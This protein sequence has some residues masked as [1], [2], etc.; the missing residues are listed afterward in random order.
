ML[1]HLM[2]G[3]SLLAL[4]LHDAENEAGSA[5]TPAELK[6]EEIAKNT[7]IGDPVEKEEKEEDKGEID[8]DAEI[9]PEEVELDADGNPIEKVEETAEEKETR[10]KTEREAAKANRKEQRIQKRIDTAVA[11]QKT[12]EAEVI[13]L[14]AQLAAKTEGGETLTEADVQARADAIA[15]EKFTAKEVERAQD[16]FTAR[17]DKL[18]DA[19][20]KLDKDFT[21]NVNLMA[22]ELG[23]IPST[24]VNSI[25]ELENGAE[26]LK[27]MVDDVDEAEKIYDLKNKPVR[28]GMA[29]ARISDR[30][31]EEKKPKPKVISK[32]PNPKEPVNGSRA[33]STVITGK[34]STEEYI[35]K[36][37]AQMKEKREAGR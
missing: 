26:V 13:K 22:E 1:K 2:S 20:V 23:P 34:E 35:R 17:C 5:K 37:Q 32:V 18:H 24:V 6:R 31:I 9:D 33:T 16:E 11:A 30:L 25:S 28:L 14:K 21:R 36:R 4:A 15:N 8:P 29:L 3:S 19:A 27:F 10:E 7:V 12:A